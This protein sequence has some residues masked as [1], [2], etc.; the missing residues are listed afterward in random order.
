[1]PKFEYASQE[2]CFPPVVVQKHTTSVRTLNF[3]ATESGGNFQAQLRENAMVK[4][5]GATRLTLT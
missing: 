4:V 5:Y 3:E 1:L 2:T